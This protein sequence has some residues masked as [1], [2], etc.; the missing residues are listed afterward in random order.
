M[1]TPAVPQRVDLVITC[2][3]RDLPKLALAHDY[4]R[5]FLPMKQLHVI[6][7]RRDF[8]HF[9]NALG[10]EVVLLDENEMIPGVTVQAL[11]VIP[12][13][14]LSQGVGW[15]FQQ[16]L[17]Y[18][19]AF[20]KPEDDH[21]L[22]WDADTIPLRPMEFFD[23]QGRMLLTRARE[24]HAPYFA[25]YE[26]ILGRPA[27]REFSFIAQHML[28]RK[29]ILREML[30]EI[31]RHCPGDE[32]WAWK[33]MRNLAGEGSNRFSEYETY[34]HHLKDRYPELVVFRDLPWL[35]HGVD[36]CGRHPSPEALAKLGGRYYYASFEESD[37]LYRRAGRKVR[38]WLRGLGRKFRQKG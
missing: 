8:V 11:K 3:R 38:G 29:S 27:H 5:R 25:T 19:F 37:R 6:T 18:Q 2:L 7:P 28:V 1:D 22:I 14:R 24:F 23:A 31:E 16:L 33:I 13:A 12:M 26:K 34:G 35:R 21:Y 4:L 30:G 20:L 10:S 32:N 36:E 17:K 9:Q 15:Y